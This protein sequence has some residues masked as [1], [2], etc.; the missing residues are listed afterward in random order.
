MYWFALGSV[1]GGGSGR[2]GS[3]RRGAAPAHRRGQRQPDPAIP[4]CPDADTFLYSV[5]RVPRDAPGFTTLM[6]ASDI[7][8]RQLAVYA[9]HGPEVTDDQVDELVR[10]DATAHYTIP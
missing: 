5:P 8:S 7:D 1:R 4:A 10:T 3:R 9:G 2:R 6:W